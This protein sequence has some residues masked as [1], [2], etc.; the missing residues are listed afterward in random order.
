MSNVLVSEKIGGYVFAWKDLGISITVSRLIVHKSDGRVTGEI[1]VQSVNDAGDMINIFP[2]TQLNFSSDRTRV[3][4]AKNLS[5]KYKQFPWG[6]ILDQLCDGV[7]ER[8][9]KGEP[10]QELWTSAEGIKPPEPLLEPIL[11]KGLPTV[12]YGDKGVHK[13]TLALAFYFCLVLPWH[14]NPLGLQ[15]PDRSVKTLIL[16]WETEGTITQYYGKKIQDGHG[17]PGLIVQHRRCHL[18]LADDL[19]QIWGH[20]LDKKAEV[21]IIDSLAAAAGGELNKP[22]IALTFFSALRQLKT[23]SLL[24]AQNSKDPESQRKTIFG[25]VFFTYYARNI[26]ELCKSEATSE[27]VFDIALFHRWCNIGKLHKPMSFNLHY[28]ETGLIIARQPFVAAEFITKLTND[29]K[30][31]EFLKR[32]ALK[33][34]E[35]AKATGISENY[36]R[37][38]LSRL[39]KKGLVIQIDDSWGLAVREDS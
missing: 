31:L 17:L 26:L 5:V 11:Y 20:I 28:N 13:S 25:S 2:S 7:Q 3:G 10:V 21:I 27:D 8:A 33:P 37:V 4:L 18:P 35:V 24:I 22:E 34:K 39:K 16:D 14:D 23:T 15:A 32:G 1:V 36:A 29:Q 12:I 9:R 38:S 19:E 30:I 6:E